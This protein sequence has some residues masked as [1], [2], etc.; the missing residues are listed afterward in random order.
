M[1]G[2]TSGPS[3]TTPEERAILVLR[4]ATRAF[5]DE[6][7]AARWLSEPNPRFGGIAPLVCATE[8]TANCVLVCQYLDD[9]ALD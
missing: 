3:V 5:G 6:A 8:T 9:L 7:K 2:G 1:T 4:M